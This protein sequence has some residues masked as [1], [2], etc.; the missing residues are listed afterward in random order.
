MIFLGGGGG[1]RSQGTPPP[2]MKHCTGITHNS[3]WQ[4]LVIIIIFIKISI[5]HRIY[6]R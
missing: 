2:P 4:A 1:G 3:F 6:S 5:Y